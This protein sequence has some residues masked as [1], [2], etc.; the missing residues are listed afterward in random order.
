MKKI[1]IILATLVLL[2]SGSCSDDF[3]E[4]FNPNTITTDN[5][6]VTQ[7]DAEAAIFGVYAQLQSNNLYRRDFFRFESVSDN[8]FNEFVGDGFFA[9]SEG[10]HLNTNGPISNFFRASYTVVNRA[11]LVLENVPVMKLEDDVKNMI[12]GEAYF[13][14]ALSYLNLTTLWGDVPLILES[15]V[16]GSFSGNSPLSSTR[17]QMIAD[18]KKVVDNNMLP[19]TNSGRATHGAATALL[20]KYHLYEGQWSE[21]VARGEQVMGMGYDLFDDYAQLFLPENENDNEIIFSV[22]F[23]AFVG[24]ESDNFSGGYDGNRPLPNLADEYETTDGLMITDPGSIYD[25]SNPFDNR[26][27]RFEATILHEGEER[28]AGEGLWDH[29]DSDTELAYQKYTVNLRDQGGPQDFYVIRYADVLLMY[30][31]AKNETLSSPDQTTYDAVNEVRN[32]VGMPDLPG[33]L[34]KDAMRDRIRH[35]RRVELAFEGLRLYDITRWGI[36]EDRYVNGVTF[37]TRTFE[38]PKHNL[39][40]FPLGEIDN[41]PLITQNNGW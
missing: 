22:K 9:I 16:V 17:A 18:L 32:R 40:P 11:N 13:L 28:Y 8:G 38:S 23:A 30:A 26:D 35:E 7:A 6:W 39:F 5:F 25:P 15:N 2:V 27:P 34:S 20:M 12:L 19:S 10:R 41:N 33:G 3:L 4:T 36:V 29:K 31:E 14:R 1:N 24:D 21:A 37:H